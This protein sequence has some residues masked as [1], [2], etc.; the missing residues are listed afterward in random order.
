MT[1]EVVVKEQL[2]VEAIAAGDQ[3]TCELRKRS[4]FGLVASFWLYTSE[5]NRW[6]LIIATPLVESRGPLYVHNIIQDILAGMGPLSLALQ[7]YT[8]SVLSLNYPF[9]KALLSTG[10]FEIEELPMGTRLAPTVRM[11][12]R[13]TLSRVKDVFVEDALVYYLEG[14][15]A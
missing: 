2:P 11:P 4:D 8:V 9:V 5:S 12:R 7:W 6:K 13:I 3:L 1:Q 15:A 10:R 14:Q